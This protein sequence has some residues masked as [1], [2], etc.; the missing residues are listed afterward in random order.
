MICGANKHIFLERFY[1]SY[2][3][4]SGRSV[5]FT[6]KDDFLRRDD[7]SKMSPRKHDKVGITVLRDFVERPFAPLPENRLILDK[8]HLTYHNNVSFLFLLCYHFTSYH[9]N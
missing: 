8:A 4:V 1:A 3:M 9:I 5:S 7:Q 2:L 6:K